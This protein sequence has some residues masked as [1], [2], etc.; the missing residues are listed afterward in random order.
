MN[1]TSVKR[2]ATTQARQAIE[3][4][5]KGDLDRLEEFY[6]ADFVD[7]VNDMVFHGREGARHSVGL[8]RAVFD[9][10]RLDVEEQVTEGNRI[11]SRWVLHGSN[12]GRKVELRGIVISRVDE[13]GHIAEDWGYSDTFS[14]LRQMG[15]V[16]TI[17]LGVEVLTRR[18]K[19][20]KAS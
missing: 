5:C 17:L 10:L 18:V 6:S 13:D 14:L 9:D 8:Y 4:V 19:L 2:D 1:E 12:R 3:I 11:A 15:V 7:H 16:R 20:P